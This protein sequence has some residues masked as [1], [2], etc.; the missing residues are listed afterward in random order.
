MAAEKIREI[1]PGNKP[2]VYI[3]KYQNSLLQG[4]ITSIVWHLH[5][6]IV[7]LTRRNVINKLS[8]HSLNL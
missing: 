2:E 6:K 7:Y 1:Q 3:S 8:Q 5:N 4:V